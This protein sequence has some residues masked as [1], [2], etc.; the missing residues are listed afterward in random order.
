[1]RVD[2]EKLRKF[3]WEMFIVDAYLGNFDRHNGN[4]GFITD[5]TSGKWEI[6]SIFDCGSCLYAQADDETKKEIMTQEDAL[7]IRIYQR[8]QSALR[9]DNRKISYAE[10]LS[11][12]VN[13]ECNRALRQ[14]A[15][16]IEEKTAEID[17]LIYNKTPLSDIDRDFYSFVLRKR[18]ELIINYALQNIT[19]Q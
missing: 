19:N 7:K 11:S 4:W 18:K 14:I 10:F 6:A 2:P 9:Y 5:I 8:P 12:G 16:R 3:F 15:Q 17:D 13:P 1:M